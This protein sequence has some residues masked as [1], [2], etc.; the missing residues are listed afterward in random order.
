MS[1]NHEAYHVWWRRQ[2][3]RAL[4][5]HK[6]CP[7]DAFYQI[8]Q[9]TKRSARF[10]LSIFVFR[11]TKSLFYRIFLIRFAAP[12]NGCPCFVLRTGLSTCQG[13]LLKTIMYSVKAITANNL[14]TLA[15]IG[16][17][18]L[19]AISA[20]VYVWIEGEIDC[21]NLHIYKNIKTLFINLTKAT[22]EIID[23]RD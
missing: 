1:F 11:V 8:F 9:F 2:N 10:T 5:W 23:Q 12:D 15:F 19:F 17:L 14:E 3:L 16:F 18:L 7:N 4:W 13:R 6:D 22:G 20:S 21:S